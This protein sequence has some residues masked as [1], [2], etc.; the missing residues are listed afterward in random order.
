MRWVL[1]WAALTGT[2]MA[3]GERA[4]DFDYYV[5]ALS[6]SPSFC[7]LKGEA[8]DAEQCAPGQRFGWVLHGLWP[9]DERSWPAN[10]PTSEPNP[11][12]RQTAG[13]ADIM[14]SSGLAWYQW[15]KHGRCSGLTAEGYFALARAAYRS[16]KQPEVLQRLDQPVK[17]PAR[18]IEEAWLEANP[19]LRPD[20]VTVTCQSG[21][22][23]ETRICLT[24]A[25]VPRPCGADAAMD[26]TSR[27]ALFE[28]IR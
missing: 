17:L 3:D 27:D 5:L 1:I 11:S 26:C 22:I 20:M 21:R 28:P 8:A 4:G 23:M 25:L 7:A 2:A 19:D 9:Q 16:V 14:G 6:W 10:C 15:K 13:M 24:K 12:R 18:V